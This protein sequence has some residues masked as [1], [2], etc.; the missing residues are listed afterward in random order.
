[1]NETRIV[2]KL[3]ADHRLESF[4]CGQPDLNQWLERYALQNQR[5]G[6]AQTYVGLVDGA[7]T[8]FYSLSVGQIEFRDASER[9]RKG[10][11]RH[12]IPIMLLARLAVDRHWQGRGLGRALLR[13]AILRTLQA[14]EIAGIRALVVHAKDER[15]RQYYEQ[16]D[17][18]PSPSD[19]LH[20]FVLL[21]DLRQMLAEHS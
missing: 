19:P 21:K 5:A 9:L 15:A 8:G 4:D 12:P 7:V 14:A 1:M 20:L 3:R 17:F 16:F 2:E 18:V 6:S 11:A 10:L 13:D